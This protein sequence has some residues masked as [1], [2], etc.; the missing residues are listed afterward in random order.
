MALTNS[1]YDAIMRIYNSIQIK[2]KH[3]LDERTAEVYASCP[4]IRDIEDQIISLSIE[5]APKV[6]QSGTNALRD[7]KS[8][9]GKLI[10]KRKALLAS[11]G[12]PEDY[13][14][15]IYDCPDCMDTGFVNGHHCR[16]FKQKVID[17]FYMQSNL[18]NIVNEENFSNFSFDWYSK[19]YTDPA[20]GLTPYHNMQQ[21]VGIC[22]EFISTFDSTFNNLLLYGD[23][24]V[25]K[26]FLSN[27][28]AKEILDHSHSVIYLTAIELFDIFADHDFSHDK[29]GEIGQ[30]MN[31]YILNCELLIIDDLGTELSNSFTNSKLF[32]CINERILKQ[33]STIISTNLSIS[34]LANNYS[35]R[36]FSRI[37]SSYTMLKLYG[38]DIR[39]LKRNT[40]NS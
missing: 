2:N 38:N 6:I 31:E 28:I 39:V 4:E 14:T 15:D 33:K 5:N 23:T 20:T 9:L 16:C 27:C 29:S 37:T 3:L 26:T 17:M 35:E 13:L 24:G 34:E 1:Q 32:Y 11:L 19:D 8:R 25:G 21:V 22:K 40:K 12:H 7:Y 18:K 36:I 10:D 30:T